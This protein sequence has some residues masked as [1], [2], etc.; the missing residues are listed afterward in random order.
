MS[1]LA[2]Q[3]GGS[4]STGTQRV[5]DIVPEKVHQ[6]VPLF[7]GSKKEVRSTAAVFL[8]LSRFAPRTSGQEFTSGLPRASR[9]IARRLSTW[10]A[11][12]STEPVPPALVPWVPLLAGPVEQI[13]LRSPLACCSLL[14]TRGPRKRHAARS[15]QQET[16]GS[17]N[18]ERWRP[19]RSAAAPRR[20]PAPLAPWRP[21]SAA[22]AVWRCVPWPLRCARENSAAGSG[23]DQAPVA[24]QNHYDLAARGCGSVAAAVGRSLTLSLWPHTSRG[25]RGLFWERRASASPLKP[26]ISSPR[27]AQGAFLGARVAARPAAVATKASR[28]SSS[29]VV[30]RAVKSKAGASQQYQVR[31]CGA[32]RAWGG[33][34]GAAAGTC[35]T[36]RSAR[37][38]FRRHPCGTQR[39]SSPWCLIVAAGGRRQAPGPVA[40]AVHRRGRRHPGQGARRR[41]GLPSL[42]PRQQQDAQR[43]SECASAA[44]PAPLQA[45]TGNAAKAGIKSGDTI[46][47]ASSFFGDELW[48]ADKLGFVN[49]AIKVRASLF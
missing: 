9:S 42:R 21:L 12:P 29:S 41:G 20:L 35:T 15:E 24:Q 39:R 4:G 43:H 44:W 28:S 31:A 10:R 30:A 8:L 19:R 40:G 16:P 33:P 45:A 47:Y 26:A 5:L 49:N 14:A 1:M 22:L 17:C 32:G 34:A 11:S 48:P 37:P 23:E 46:I 13:F 36:W 3:A 38:L 25:D 2:E 7:I 18:S 27:V 6:R